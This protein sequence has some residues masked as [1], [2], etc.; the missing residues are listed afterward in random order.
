MAFNCVGS[1]GGPCWQAKDPPTQTAAPA[2]PALNTVPKRED[3]IN[4]YG[5]QANSAAYGPHRGPQAAELACKP[6]NWLVSRRN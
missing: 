5:L 4:S 3:T 1:R 6:Q 2:K